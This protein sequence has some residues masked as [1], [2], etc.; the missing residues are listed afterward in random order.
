LLR[1]RFYT[2]RIKSEQ[3]FWEA[4]R[5]DL[6]K[7]GLAEADDD[8][9]YLNYVLCA[10]L[11]GEGDIVAERLPNGNARVFVCAARVGEN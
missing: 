8:V 6:H 9:T 3:E 7:V 5:R 10:E 1:T 11:V 2:T 4:V